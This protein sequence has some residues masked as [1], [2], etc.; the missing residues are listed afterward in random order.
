MKVMK[1]NA[2]YLEARRKQL[3][4]K[5]ILE[6]GVVF[7][8]LGLGIWQTGSRLNLLT[9]VAVLGCLPASKSLVELIM[10][11]PHRSVQ[12]V[13]AEEIIANTSLLTSAF[14]IVMTS[15]EK[16]MPIDCV[17]IQ[18]NTIC[19]FSSAQKIDAVYAAKHIRQ[20]LMQNQYTKVSVK[21]FTD[22]N[23]F[24]ARAKEMQHLAEESR[25]DTTRKE[26]AVR[27]I[28]L[29]ISL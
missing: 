4:L 26:L 20:I 13:I 29:N 24:L 9:V 10:V 16:I 25:P 8:L 12:H 23:A 7:A 6:F 17:L 27:Q 28:L 22:Y 21:I 3:T 5:V 19:G 14:D 1:G 11:F 18:D 2:G 15:R